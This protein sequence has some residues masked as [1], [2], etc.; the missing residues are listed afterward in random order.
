[1]LAGVA[2]TKKSRL[3]MAYAAAVTNG[4]KTASASAKGALVAPSTGREY[5]Q[6]ANNRVV[7]VLVSGMK[8]P[9]SLHLPNRFRIRLTGKGAAG[10]NPIQLGGFLLSVGAVK[11]SRCWEEAQYYQLGNPFERFVAFSP[12]DTDVNFT[13]GAEYQC[14]FDNKDPNSTGSIR[15]EDCRVT[16][17][18]VTLSFVAPTAQQDYVEE[19][20]RLAELQ[21]I[22][23]RRSK[24]R[25]D[26]WHFKTS[27]ERE[28][29]PHY[30][31]VPMRSFSQEILVTIPNRWTECLHCGTVN[32]RTN[33]CPQEKERKRREYQERQK[34]KDQKAA[35]TAK[36]IEDARKAFDEKKK[37]QEEEDQARNQLM[38]ENEEK[39]L[40]EHY[41]LVQRRKR[42]SRRC[43]TPKVSGVDEG[44]QRIEAEEVSSSPVL[45]P[46]RQALSRD[47]FPFL[48][49]HEESASASLGWDSKYL[50]L[51]MS[52]QQKQRPR[53]RTTPV[54]DSETTD[55]FLTPVATNAIAKNLFPWPTEIQSV[56]L[57][58]ENDSEQS[59]EL[60]GQEA[61]SEENG[62]SLEGSLPI[63]L[64]D[65]GPAL[66]IPTPP[67]Q[68]DSEDGEGALEIVYNSGSGEEN[69]CEEQPLVS[70]P[71]QSTNNGAS[72][73]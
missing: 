11:S 46:K 57:P 61:L 40:E 36:K 14:A 45:P 34:K 31:V 25:E 64:N 73:L 68:S 60:E 55:V 59:D 72:V 7:T 19:I 51:G 5:Q 17:T 10:F 20:C 15:I 1:M 65:K 67:N 35:E 9:E 63:T 37:K 33:Q 6:S 24:Y 53:P 66:Q 13:H 48:R 43:S 30:I 41:Q 22:G 29:I 27:A 23:L 12:N 71:T 42:N 8:E 47:E 4:S 69:S 26:Q 44:T 21:P 28:A 2:K 32:H 70:E 38:K 52:P 50:D 39:R 3:K 49:R 62:C 16:E 58:A 54:V 56:E 18:S